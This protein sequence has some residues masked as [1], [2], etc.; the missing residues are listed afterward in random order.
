MF[1]EYFAAL[2]PPYCT[3]RIIRLV[4]CFLGNLCFRVGLLPEFS[5][6]LHRARASENRTFHLVHVL[7]SSP[8]SRSDFN[9]SRVGRVHKNILSGLCSILCK[10]I[11][12]LRFCFHSSRNKRK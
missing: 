3:T 1:P 7:G 6:L 12:S 11:T 5:E 9:C 4:F 2:H 8:F 10:A